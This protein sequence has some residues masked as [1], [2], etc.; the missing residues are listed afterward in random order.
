MSEMIMRY[1]ALPVAMLLAGISA[2]AMD[3]SGADILGLRLGMSKAE[4][5]AQLARQGFS[6]TTLP[7]ACSAS[8]I[9]PV[10][11]KAVTRDGALL[12]TLS[13]DTGA[14]QVEYVF[15]GHG[16]GEP[17][18]IQAAM[19]DRFGDPN[20]Q[21]PMI[22]CRAVGPD[23]RCPDEQASLTFRPQTLTLLLKSGSIGRPR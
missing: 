16:A 12:I 11:I 22:W 10:M 18:E 19:T 1:L 4:V 13:G 2:Q 15:R 20:Q 21:N 14:Q 8:G 6:T 9:C 3:A 17:Q 5:T 23:G 7:G